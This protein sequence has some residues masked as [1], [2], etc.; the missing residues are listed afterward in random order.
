MTGLVLLGGGGH[1]S[2]VL[3][4]IEAMVRR[5]HSIDLVYVA[6]RVGLG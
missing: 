2:D 1:A 5:G 6:C 3:A 4:V